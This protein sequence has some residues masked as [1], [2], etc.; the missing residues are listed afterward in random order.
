MQPKLPKH[1]GTNKMTWTKAKIL[2]IYFPI[3]LLKVWGSYE[4]CHPVE[5]EHN[6]STMIT[7]GTEWLLY[8]NDNIEDIYTGYI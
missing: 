7:A 3:Y 4:I 1:V 5:T 6:L 8:L 2:L